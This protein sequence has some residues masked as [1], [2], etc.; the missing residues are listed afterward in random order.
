MC[1]NYAPFLYSCLIYITCV[2]QFCMS[3]KFKEVILR[4][5][6]VSQ[7]SCTRFVKNLKQRKCKCQNYFF[8]VFLNVFIFLLEDIFLTLI[9]K[10]SYILTALKPK[11][12]TH[13]CKDF[14]YITQY[15]GPFL[16]S[17]KPMNFFYR[18]ID[19]FFF[20]L[21]IHSR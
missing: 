11:L 1:Y 14:F 4:E 5:K 16:L 10:W 18:F 15:N 13:F 3:K 20:V 21:I 6:L 7:V 12:L 8:I 2:I 19:L 9:T 17:K